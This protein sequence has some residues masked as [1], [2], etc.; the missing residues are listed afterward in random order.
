MNY[1]RNRGECIL[2][3]IDVVLNFASFSVRFLF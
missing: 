3:L 2:I 1:S